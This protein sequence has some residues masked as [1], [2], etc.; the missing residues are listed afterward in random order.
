[1]RSLPTG[2]VTFLFTDIE[3]ST[4]LLHELGDAYAD[5]LADHRRVLRDAFARH[6]GV[7][8]DTQGDA[9]FVAF[10]RASDALA[11]AREATEA[12]NGPIRVRVGVHTGEPLVTDEG[13]VG[14]DVHRAARIAAAGHG[15][16]ILVS[17]STRDLVG[18]EGLRDQGEH[19]L[20]DLTAP[21]RIYQLGDGDFPPLK[22]LH[23]TNLPVQPTPLVGR[24]KE[25]REISALLPSSR[26]LTLT[27]AGGS[28][29]TRLALHAAA[30]AVDEFPDGVWFVSLAALRDPRLIESSIA[31]VLGS[32][33]ALADFLPG[34]SLLLLLDNL[35]QLLPDAAPLISSLDAALLVTSRE[36]LNVAGEQEYEVPPLP[37]DDAVALFTQRARQL[38][39]RFE[40]DDAVVAIARRVDGLPLALELAAALVKVLT[41]QQVNQRLDDSLEVLVS[42]RRDAPA[43]QRT[44]RAAIEWSYQ[45]LGP[46]EQRLFTALAVFA[47]S[48]SIEA[49]E[50]VAEADVRL[51][52]ALVDKSLLR[53]TGEGRF[54]MLETI[55]EFALERLDD[56]RL[57]KAAR[58]RHARWIEDLAVS[59]VDEL[60]GDKQVDCLDRLTAEHAN[61]RAAL[62]YAIASEDA[63]LAL[64][65]GGSLGRFWIFRGHDREGRRWLDESLAL[66]QTTPDDHRWR[67]LYWNTILASHLGDRP[68]ALA[69]AEAGLALARELGDRVSTSASAIELARRLIDEGRRDRA[70]ILLDEAAR[71]ASEGGDD[72]GIDIVES[73]RGQLRLLD[74]DPTAAL[75]H[76]ERSLESGRRVE[77]TQLAA[78]GLAD[79]ALAQAL[80]GQTEASRASLRESLRLCAELE[81]AY[82]VA[83]CLQIAAELAVRDADA[84]RA[85]ALLT[86]ADGLMTALGL[87]GSDFE[88]ELYRRPWHYVLQLVAEDDLERLGREA[89]LGDL[90]EAIEFASQYLD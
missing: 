54:F 58:R 87:D 22:S 66:P 39:P 50:V 8:V 13:Y 68:A 53:S 73:I 62:S 15:G 43:R 12:L 2:T 37:L 36:R 31:E 44:L 78:R 26:L 48:F 61:I 19:R 14:M 83:L 76:F 11:A 18:S 6:G 71:L 60:R 88:S 52:G 55:R 85:A 80:C 23:R 10:A 81:M 74:G 38:K 42:G 59:A 49:A 79:L 72:R 30:D 64:T 75:A 63:Q 40:P 9:F 32:R 86:R 51:I 56:S 4:R 1:M 3:G 65:I 28:G 69:A 57:G 33:E 77:D 35:E 46:E 20:K 27:G 67:A 34:K 29:K 89:P 82:G 84:L 41:P 45:L 70:D 17:Q 24:E 16:Q 21:E 90:N 7:E 47:G 25:L 5:G